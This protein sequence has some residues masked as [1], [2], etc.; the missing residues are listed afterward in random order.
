MTVVFTEWLRHPDT[1]GAG[2][3]LILGPHLG[4]EIWGKWFSHSVLLCP[5]L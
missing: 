5:Y 1:A 4:P 2:E 3:D